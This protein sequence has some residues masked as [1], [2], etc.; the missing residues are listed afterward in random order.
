MKTLIVLTFLTGSDA[1]TIVPT[2]HVELGR[3]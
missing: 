2:S 1:V 3:R